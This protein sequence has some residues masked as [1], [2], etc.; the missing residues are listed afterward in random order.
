MWVHLFSNLDNLW[1]CVYCGSLFHYTR[2]LRGLCGVGVCN[3]CRCICFLVCIT[4]VG[5][6]FCSLYNLCCWVCFQFCTTC[7]GVFV[8]S[9]YNLCGCLCFT[10]QSSSGACVELVYGNI[11]GVLV[12]RFILPVWVRLFSTL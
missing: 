10:A 11:V 5:P 12:S 1:G 2:Q 7:A 4:C 8:L 9:V 3:D 6:L